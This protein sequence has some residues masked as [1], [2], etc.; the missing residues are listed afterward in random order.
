MNKLIF[1]SVTGTES[2]LLSTDLLCKDIINLWETLG[3]CFTLRLPCD[4]TGKFLVDGLISVIPEDNISLRA[5]A[6]DFKAEGL[7]IE[8]PPEVTTGKLSSDPTDAWTITT[9][10]AEA[11][12]AKMHYAPNP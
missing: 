9:D 11:W 5:L 4:D 1:N 2:I 8:I 6:F 10:P 7:D 3:R 12:F